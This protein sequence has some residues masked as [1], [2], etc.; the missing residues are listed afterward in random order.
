MAS[1]PR[2]PAT[3]RNALQTSLHRCLHQLLRGCL[4]D[5]AADVDAIAAK[6]SLASAEHSA[7]LGSARAR[8]SF[9][10]GVCSRRRTRNPRR[11]HLGEVQSVPEIEVVRCR[12]SGIRHCPG[13][14]LPWPLAAQLRPLRTSPT[15]APRGNYRKRFWKHSCHS[16]FF[17]R[18]AFLCRAIFVCR[19]SPGFAPFH[20]D[21]PARE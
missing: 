18:N 11:P 15:E 21:G 17:S 8:A 2:L 16:I 4:A 19:I 1:T 12:A 10:G 13:A 6:W 7:S 5:A 20:A 14:S 9:Q 3:R